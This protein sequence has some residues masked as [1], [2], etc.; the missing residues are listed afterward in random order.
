M[1]PK[2][3]KYKKITDNWSNGLLIEMNYLVKAH[4]L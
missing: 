2:N 4:G 3:K 1:N